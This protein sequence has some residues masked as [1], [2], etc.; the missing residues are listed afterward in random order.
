MRK[1]REFHRPNPRDLLRDLFL[2]RIDRDR[3]SSPSHDIQHR[4]PIQASDQL[5]PLMHR[6]HQKLLRLISRGIKP[7]TLS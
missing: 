6:R 2:A 7:Q 3:P 1:P 5:P 4:L